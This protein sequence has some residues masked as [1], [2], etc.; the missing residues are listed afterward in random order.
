MIHA[1]VVCLNQN[2]NDT[3]NTYGNVYVYVYDCHVL[4]YTKIT[5]FL[6][7]IIRQFHIIR[8]IVTCTHS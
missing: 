6:I 3:G 7:K 5:Y 2:H 1:G 4:N 8:L